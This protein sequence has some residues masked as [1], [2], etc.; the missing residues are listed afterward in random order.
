MHLNSCHDVFHCDKTN[1]STYDTKKEND[2]F[3]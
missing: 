1:F 3:V 2:E